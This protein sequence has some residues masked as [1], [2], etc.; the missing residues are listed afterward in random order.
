[1]LIHIFELFRYLLFS[2]HAM[3]WKF[4]KIWQRLQYFSYWC[5]KI[6]IACDVCNSD[7][8]LLMFWVKYENCHLKYQIS[9]HRMP[10]RNEMQ[11]LQ[12][13]VDEI[14][15]IEHFSWCIERIKILT[16]IHTHP[17]TAFSLFFSVIH[18]FEII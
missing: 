13:N 4:L 11:K 16:S 1:M 9:K 5:V 2:R 6:D 12:R 18:C 10:C 8:C 15:T 7:Q 14:V 3:K 17:T